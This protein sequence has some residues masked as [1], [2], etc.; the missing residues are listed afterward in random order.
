[1]AGRRPKTAD[2]HARN[3]NP[4]KRTHAPNPSTAPGEPVRPAWMKGD[5]AA[6]WDR[7]TTILRVEKRLNLSE[8]PAL[9]KLCVAHARWMRLIRKCNSPRTPLTVKSLESGEKPNPVF[10]MERLASE[11]CRKM[12]NDFGLTP[13]TRG[14]VKLAAPAETDKDRLRARFFGPQL[15]KGAGAGA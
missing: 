8:A 1:M 12:Y 15:V 11:Q 6:E 3:G 13:G 10:Q 9:E 5:A 4:G 2:E 14:R 7:L